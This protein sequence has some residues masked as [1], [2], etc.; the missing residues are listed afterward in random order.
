ML[1]VYAEQTH[2]K[3]VTDQELLTAQLCSNLGKNNLI[4]FEPNI[5]T[6]SS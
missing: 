5:Q 3:L 2:T 4:T 1:R 6:L